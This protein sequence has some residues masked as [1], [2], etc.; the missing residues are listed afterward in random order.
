MTRIRTALRWL[1]DHYGEVA[2]A[3]VCVGLAVVVWWLSMGRAR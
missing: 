3:V 2:F 1:R